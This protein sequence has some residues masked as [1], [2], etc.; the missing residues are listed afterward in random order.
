[1][2]AFVQRGA[3][4]GGGSL[5]SCAGPFLFLAEPL[6]PSFLVYIGSPAQFSVFP[7]LMLGLGRNG[8]DIAGH[9]FSASQNHRQPEG[10][11]LKD[12][13]GERFGA[14]RQVGEIPLRMPP[15]TGEKGAIL[16]TH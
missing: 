13:I 5:A 2:L 3:G 15:W 8:R 9:A 6:C 14:Q 10:V 1:M 11:P 12:L 7:E 16:S 4:L